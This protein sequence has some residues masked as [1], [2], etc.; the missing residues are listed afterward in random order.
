MSS[1]SDTFFTSVGCMDGRVQD[2]VAN[3]GRKK[4]GALF[5][6]TI[7]EAGLVGLLSE[8]PDQS[9]LES[10]KKK[11]NISIGKHHS[12]GILVHGHE[13]CAGNPVSKEEHV[14]D[15]RK[16]IEVIKTLTGAKIPVLGLFIKR[17]T[18]NPAIWEASEV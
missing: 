6:D 3:F 8:N 13:E 5:A 11:L 2:P 10:I 15:I 17:S 7:T 12:R 16:S 14:E 18:H 9:L 4:F 1:A